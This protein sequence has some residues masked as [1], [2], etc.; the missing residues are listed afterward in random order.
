YTQAL[1]DSVPKMDRTDRLRAIDG[2]PPPLWDL[3]EGC[4]FASRCSNV[5][6]LCRNEYP[7]TSLLDN[8]HSVACWMTQ[9][10]WNN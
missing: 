6:D 1:M 4:R 3:P 9:T 10:E 5:K 7:N 2:Q 8:N